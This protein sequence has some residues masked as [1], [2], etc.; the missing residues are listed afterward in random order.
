M[1]WPSSSSHVD[2]NQATAIL[3]SINTLKE[4][5]QGHVFDLQ[6]SLKTG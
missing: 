6:I 4:I 5:S 3:G 2:I 1:L